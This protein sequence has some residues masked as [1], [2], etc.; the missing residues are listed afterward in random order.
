MYSDKMMECLEV[1]LHRKFNPEAQNGMLGQTMLFYAVMNKKRRSQ[2]K[3][4]KYIEVK[5]SNGKQVL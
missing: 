2:E 1:L 5:K 3:L 4:M